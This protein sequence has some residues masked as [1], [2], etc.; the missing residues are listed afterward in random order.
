MKVFIKST[1]GHLFFLHGLHAGRLP[2][3]VRINASLALVQVQQ[4]SLFLHLTPPVTTLPWGNED[5]LSQ[6]GDL[7]LAV[8]MVL[9]REICLAL[10]H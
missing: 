3:W 5:Y 4:M 6:L 10:A 8:L 1:K 7:K 2:V 9:E